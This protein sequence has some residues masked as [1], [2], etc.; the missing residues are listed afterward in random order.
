MHKSQALIVYVAKVI[1]AE[2]KQKGVML[3]CDNIGTR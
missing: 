3:L 2:C 1:I